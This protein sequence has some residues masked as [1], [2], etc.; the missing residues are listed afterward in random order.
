MLHCWLRHLA[1]HAHTIKNLTGCRPS[2][3]EVAGRDERPRDG[4]G[5]HAREAQPDRQQSREAQPGQERTHKGSPARERAADRA[6]KRA[7]ATTTEATHQ[8][9]GEKR[10]VG[11]GSLALAG[12]KL[13]CSLE[14]CQ[15]LG[16]CDCFWTTSKAL[17]GQ[18]F[19]CNA[20]M[21]EAWHEVFQLNRCQVSA[22]KLG[23]MEI[24]DTGRKF[25]V[26]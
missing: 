13:N 3:A 17:H 9:V 5:Q 2:K 11:V 16:D 18:S 14:S 25:W 21:L 26:S 6:V 20:S 4:G 12:S 22:C 8:A 1:T 23:L 15:L 24:P 19:C 7:S 10:Q